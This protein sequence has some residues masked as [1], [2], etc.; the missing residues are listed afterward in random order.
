MQLHP[1]GNN[2]NFHQQ[3]SFLHVSFLLSDWNK[4]LNAPALGRNYYVITGR[5]APRTRS[6]EI[7][8]VAAVSNCRLRISVD[9]LFPAAS[10]KRRRLNYHVAL[11]ILCRVFGGIKESGPR[12]LW[13]IHPPP[14]LMRFGAAGRNL[15][16]CAAPAEYFTDEPLGRPLLLLLFIVS[17]YCCHLHKSE[18]SPERPN[19]RDHVQP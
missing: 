2:F 11:S 15:N 9:R 4:D 18:T 10:T 3:G 1:S 17:C 16:I 8:I 13:I 7:W 19:F 14:F 12:N 6:I 5:S